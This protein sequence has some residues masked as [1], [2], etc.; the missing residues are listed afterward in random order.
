MKCLLTIAF[1]LLAAAAARADFN[2]DVTDCQTRIL[3]QLHYTPRQPST[4]QDFYCLGIQAYQQQNDAE[5]A[6]W[7]RRSADMGHAGAQ[8]ALGYLYTTGRGVPQSYTEALKWYRRSAD[9]GNSDSLYAIGGLYQFGRGLPK[10]PEEANRWFERA[11]AAKAIQYPA[12]RSVFDEGERQYRE[13]NNPTPVETVANPAESP[14]TTD[15]PFQLGYQYE[16]G[17]GVPKNFELAARW[18]RRAAAQGDA[19]AQVNLGNLYE[20]GKGVPEDWVQAAA[21][22]T[23]SAEQ[24]NADG[25]FQ[26]GRAYLLGV[27]VRQNRATAKKWLY[28]AAQKGD[29]RAQESING[30][31]SGEEQPSLLFHNSVE[32]N[33]WLKRCQ[34]QKNN[35]CLP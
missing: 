21:W 4:A 23:K 26:L 35:T 11:K 8:N 2:A 25:M 15:V 14:K 28:E 5:S 29:P 1:F 27:G 31:R 3:P 9:Q 10:D 22:W 12:G 30:L 24:G 17:E 33:E 16:H 18:Y 6:K 20:A 32:R 19:R 34:E 7:Y 13:A